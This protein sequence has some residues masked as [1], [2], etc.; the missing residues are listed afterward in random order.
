MSDPSWNRRVWRMAG[1]IIFSS[2]SVPL[3]GA[4]DTAMVGQL[5]GAEQIAAVG[6]GTTIFNV[7]FQTLLFLRMGT[8]GLTAQAVGA[9]DGNEIRAALG[10]AIG[11]ALVI[12]LVLV[13]LQLPIAWIAFRTIGASE[14]VTSLARDYFAIRIWVAPA[15]LCNLALVGWF[16]GIQNA[17]VVLLLQVLINSLNV[18]LDFLFVLGL[19]GGVAGVAR[20][21][22]TAQYVGLAVGLTVARA[23]L[24][25]V[26]GVWRWDLLRRTGPL[27]RMLNIS[28]DIF[29]RTVC[30][31]GCMATI[32]AIGARSGDLVLATNTIMLS[33]TFVATYGLDGFAHAVAALAGSAVGAGDRKQFRTAVRYCGGWALGIALLISAV[34]LIAAPSI[35]DT[36]TE[37]A[38]VRAMSR[39]YLPWVIA[40]P[41]YSVWSFLIDGIFVGAT[42]ARDMRNMAVLS[43][44]AFAAS[45]LVFVPWLG[46]HGL[47]L[48]YVIFMLSRAVTL[49]SHYPALERTIGAAA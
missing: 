38:A 24:L 21:S 45:I 33:L 44:L 29:L 28:S 19:D 13:A 8:S 47:W 39:E 26:H 35:I 1:P 42:R 18:G 48:S 7:L 31:A 6:A 14:A 15:M 30:F 36:M 41:L 49:G 34:Y 37:D 4:V 22:L 43:A 23:K 9:G 40:G 2:V 27:K 32:T 12:G 16:I 5:P 20:A 10:R 25:D 11:M 17:R 46:N 3:L